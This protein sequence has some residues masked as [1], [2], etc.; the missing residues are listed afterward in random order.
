[1]GVHTKVRLSK[2]LMTTTDWLTS[3]PYT[4]KIFV[5][6]HAKGRVC[7]ALESGIARLSKLTF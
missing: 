4:L 5:T 3:N 7:F 2:I 6:L 1:M